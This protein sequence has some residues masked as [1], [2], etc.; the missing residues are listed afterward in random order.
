MRKVLKFIGIL[1]L[2]VVILALVCFIAPLIAVLVGSHSD[3][4]GEPSVMIVFGYR[5]DGDQMQSLLQNRLDTA[6]EYVG[7]HPDITI[8]V[9][10]GKGDGE[11]LSEA[12][13][14]FDYLVEKGIDSERILMEDNSTTTVENIRF[15][16]DLIEERNIDASKGV[17]LVSNEFHLARI[18]MLWKRAGSKYAASTLAAPS[19]PMSQKVLMHLREPIALLIDFLS[20]KF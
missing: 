15:C 18:R 5:L 4:E 19:S 10:G 9:S 7:E 8:I 2:I 3:I 16:L 11:H 14:M 6:I 20:A 1:L 17:L 12:Q 13:C